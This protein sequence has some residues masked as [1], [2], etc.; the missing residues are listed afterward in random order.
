VTWPT[1]GGGVHRLDLS[2][3]RSRDPDTTYVHLVFEWRHAGLPPPLW[4]T[5]YPFAT[6]SSEGSGPR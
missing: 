3:W 1:R 6:T 4:N 5:I 2:G